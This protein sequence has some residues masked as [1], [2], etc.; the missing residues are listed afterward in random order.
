M[1]NQNTV[2]QEPELMVVHWPGQDTVACPEHLRKLVGLA[3][4]LGFPLSWTPA[5]ETMGCDNCR[6]EKASHAQP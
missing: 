5:G 2:E 4:V 3:A 6:T 1:I